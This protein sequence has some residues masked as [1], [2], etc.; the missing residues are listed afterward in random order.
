MGIFG[1]IIRGV[2]DFFTP[3]DYPTCSKCSKCSKQE[4]KLTDQNP[5]RIFTC[6]YFNYK[7]LKDDEYVAP[8]TTIDGLKE[9][10][11]VCENYE[12]CVDNL[13]NPIHNPNI[14]SNDDYQY[15]W[16]YNAL[17]ERDK[18]TFKY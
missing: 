9:R 11:K 14:T 2:S 7:P 3:Q 6:E 17:S 4:W 8:I 1:D 18:L 13:G 10:Y 5:V 16:E 15:D 12:P